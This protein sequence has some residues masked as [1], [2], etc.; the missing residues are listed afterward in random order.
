[1][2]LLQGMLSLRVYVLFGRPKSLLIALLTCFAVTQAFNFSVTCHLIAVTYH[3][4]VEIDS[5]GFNS[6]NIELPPYSQWITPATCAVLL[7]YELFLCGLVLRYAIENLQTSL[8]KS[9]RPSATTIMHV[10]VHNNL[11]YFFIVLLAML[12]NSISQLLPDNAALVITCI[13]GILYTVVI[14]MVGPWMI[15]NLRSSCFINMNSTQGVI[16]A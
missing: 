12:L 1:M 7:A 9:P 2:F 6:C 8:W 14:N 13:S 16:T 4:N 15:L 10:I 11:I 5:F 3:V